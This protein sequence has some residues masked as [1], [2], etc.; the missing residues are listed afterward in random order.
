MRRRRRSPSD[1]PEAVTDGPEAPRTS[2]SSRATGP[3]D[4]TELHVEE[5]D[6][7]R[8][9]LGALSE[10]GHPDIELRLQVHEASGQVESV[11]LVAADGA[12]ELRP[13]AAPRHEGIWDEIRPRIAAE[14]T[15]MGGTATEVGGPFGPALQLRVPG[16]GPDGQQVVQLSSVH[17]IAGPRWLLRVSMFGRPAEDYQEDGLLE[18]TLRSVVLNR[19]NEPMAPGEA[20][21]LRVPNDARRIDGPS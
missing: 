1:E 8:A 4:S 15:R 5:D 20:L 7:T 16:V 11:L 18:T 3:W 2:D 13:F 10:V 19:G 17:G 12:M 14:A 9:D 6:E 21:P